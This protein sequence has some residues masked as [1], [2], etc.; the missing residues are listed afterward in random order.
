VVGAAMELEAGL[1]I[2]ERVEECG[3]GRWE[4]VQ[5]EVGIDGRGKFATCM[6]AGIGDKAVVSRLG[7]RWAKTCRRT[8]ESDWMAAES[9]R[10]GQFASESQL[11][12]SKVGPDVHVG[13][14]TWAAPGG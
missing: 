1:G 9:G 3:S 14:A 6:L 2:G 10:V 7:R 12:R 8:F 5:C 13:A 4:R 11:L